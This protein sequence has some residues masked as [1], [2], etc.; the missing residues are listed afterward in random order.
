MTAISS[1][2]EM[3]TVLLVVVAAFSLLVGGIGIMNI[4]YVSVKER[5]R[6]IGLIIRRR[7]KPEHFKT[8]FAR[9]RFN[10]RHRRCFRIAART[11]RLVFITYFLNCRFLLRQLQLFYR[12]WFV[13]LP[14]FSSD[15]T[16]I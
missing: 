13:H 4:M 15:G 6:E 16:G 1:T 5:T 10:Q 11:F 14:E 7:K 9:S 2:S 8:I 12:S 3:M